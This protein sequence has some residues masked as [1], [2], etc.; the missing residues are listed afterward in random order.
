MTAPMQMGAQGVVPPP[1]VPLTFL[2]ASAVG[3]VG[4]G[5]AV[6]LAAD[7][8]VASP[9]SSGAVGAVHVGVLAFLTMAVLG[10]L[11]QFGPVAGRRKLRSVRAART[12]AVLMGSAA[13][14]LPTG[15]AHGPESLVVTGGLL[16]LAAV[17]LAAWNL[18]APLSCRDGGVPVLGLRISVAYL[19]V[20]VMFGVVYAIDRQTGWFPLLSHRV[21]AHAHLGLLG[22]L[23]ITYLAVAEKLWPMF[24]LAHRPSARSGRV[25]VLATAVGTALLSAGLLFAERTWGIIGGAVVV[26]GIAAHLTSLVS[27][28]RHRR[29]PLELLHGFVVAAAFFL[30]AAIILAAVATFA[31]VAPLTRMRLV[32]AEVAALI[33]WI[34]LAVVGHAHKIVP[35]VSYS[36]LRAR[37]VRTNGA[38]GALLFGD[39][40]RRWAGRATLVA[41]AG[42]FVLIIAGLLT[43]T[44]T[45]VAVGGLWLSLGGVL[46]TWNLAERPL[47]MW[48]SARMLDAVAATQA[49]VP[50]S[51]VSG[52][53]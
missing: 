5:A 36:A 51:S 22:W 4:F 27:T 14:L 41:T 48:R 42:A 16:G 8:L 39:L 49:P 30:V 35:F 37:G 13:W 47:R 34:T 43:R 23:G 9:T 38:G 29:R 31:D 1:S 28:I 7:R 12:T 45:L 25:A 50:V 44:G 2:A 52:G 40:Y 32:S 10:A 6:A 15:F 26:V 24:L 3:L 11:H 17:L 53:H 19:V 18:S 21:L 46:A 33:A 20:T